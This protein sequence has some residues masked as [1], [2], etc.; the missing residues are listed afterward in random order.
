[1]KIVYL[2]IDVGSSSLKF[3]LMDKE[4]QLV[5]SLYLKNHGLI[6]TV[7]QGLKQILNENY[8]VRGVGITGS[9][10]KFL[11]MLIGADKICSEILAHA[12]SCLKYCPDAKTIIDI[13]AEDN[14]A[15]LFNDGYIENFIMNSMCA[16]GCGQTLEMIANRLGVQ[17]E[18]VGELACKSKNKLNI[19]SKCGIFMNSMVV[20][21]RNLGQSNEDILMGVIRGITTPLCF[22]KCKC[23]K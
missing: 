15:I 23:K 17:I 14:K 21:H 5:D 13:G 1:M 20:S 22:P 11:G 10:R 2:G 7:K 6:N 8:D 12:T 18:D 3:A 16:G 4:E 9:G 19:S